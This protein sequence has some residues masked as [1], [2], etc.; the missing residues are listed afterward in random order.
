MRRKPAERNIISDNVAD[1]SLTEQGG[2]WGHSQRRERLSEAGGDK[3][4]YQ[5]GENVAEQGPYLEDI[6]P[7]LYIG[8][9]DP[10]AVNVCIVGV[11]AAWTQA[12]GEGVNMGHILK[13]LHIL[14]PHPH[15]RAV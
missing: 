10:L 9:V 2:W 3:H 8:Y 7:G 6:V 14:R 15:P 13:P 5:V 11:I 1:G 4:G 12:L